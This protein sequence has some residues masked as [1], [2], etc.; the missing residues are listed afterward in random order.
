MQLVSML[1]TLGRSVKEARETGRKFGVVEGGF[2]GK[3]KS[4]FISMGGGVSM[5]DVWGP[6]GD[7][8]ASNGEANLDAMYAM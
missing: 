6:G 1:G 2:R 3:G 4:G 7:G 8:G 5:D